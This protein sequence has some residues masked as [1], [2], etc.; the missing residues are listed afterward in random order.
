MKNLPAIYSARVMKYSAIMVF[1]ISM[2]VIWP[3]RAYTCACCANGG[4]W[5]ERKG[6][7]NMWEVDVLNGLRLNGIAAKAGIEEPDELRITLLRT[8]NRWT[9]SVRN[10]KG[11]KGALVFRLG[12][13]MTRFI[14]DL[15][16]GII[17]NSHMGGSLYKEW[18]FEGSVWGSGILSTGNAPGTRFRLILQGR[19]NLCPSAEDFKA[20]ILQVSRRDVLY[21]ITGRFEQPDARR[22]GV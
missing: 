8:Q 6:A 21:T 18:R 22:S 14:A 2:L 4:E 9:I 16:E 10:T 19:G 20:W 5:E 15:P 11:A 17:I 7:M 1:A 12:K 13:S 3:S